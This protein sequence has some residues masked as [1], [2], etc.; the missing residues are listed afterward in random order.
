MKVAQNITDLIGRT[1]LVQLNRVAAGVKPR[2]LAKLDVRS[3]GQAVA[4][5]RELRLL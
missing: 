3:R 2:I 4:R 5:A 1:P